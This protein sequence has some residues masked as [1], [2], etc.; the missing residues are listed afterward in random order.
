[1][2]SST[3]TWSF[4]SSIP[5][6]MK[7]FPIVTLICI[8]LMSMDAVPW[9]LMMLSHNISDNKIKRNDLLNIIH[10]YFCYVHGPERVL[11]HGS[12]WR[13]L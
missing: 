10:T 5:V 6:G 7:S 11:S 9:S 4:D 8:S 3:L 2:Y 1:M 12:S 13:S